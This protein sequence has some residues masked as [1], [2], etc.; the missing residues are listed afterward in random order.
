MSVQSDLPASKTH[1]SSSIFF[2][3]GVVLFLS[4]GLTLTVFTIFYI[5]DAATLFQ[6]PGIVWDFICGVP[7]DNGATL[8]VLSLLSLTAYA[9]AAVTGVVYLIRRRKPR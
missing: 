4:F 9:A 8:P 6:L 2:I 1:D 7:N 3:A 5:R